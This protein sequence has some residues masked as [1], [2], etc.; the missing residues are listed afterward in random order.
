MRGDT[1]ITGKYKIAVR[2]GNQ[3][4]E[5]IF[6]FNKEKYG[7]KVIIISNTSETERRPYFEPRFTKILCGQTVT[8][9]NQDL[10]RHLVASGDPKTGIYDGRFSTGF[11]PSG[12]A[13]TLTIKSDRETRQ[14]FK[15]ISFRYFCSLHPNEGGTVIILP[16]EE[17]SLT[18]Q[19][20]IKLIEQLFDFSIPETDPSYFENYVKNE[21]KRVLLERYFDPN[22]L[23]LIDDQELSKIQNKLLTVVFWD[24]SRFSDLCNLLKAHPQR[25]AELYGNI[26]ELQVK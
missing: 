3:S 26:P 25:I 7:D 14:D 18:N 23:D 8:W 11:I 13:V 22:I 5:T 10:R 16:K 15:V 12:K 17:D 2:N 1:A 4:A 21:H 20:R 9:I 19:E 24:I 6:S